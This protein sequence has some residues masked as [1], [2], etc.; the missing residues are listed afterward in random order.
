M[1]ILSCLVPKNYVPI[2]QNLHSQLHIDRE[3]KVGVDRWV[4][5]K[6]VLQ[7]THDRLLCETTNQSWVILNDVILYT[8]FFLT[9]LPTY[10]TPNHDLLNLN[11]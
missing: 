7:E 1:Y 4:K 10:S 2:Q 6:T 5:N 3:G 8:F 9:Y 11:K